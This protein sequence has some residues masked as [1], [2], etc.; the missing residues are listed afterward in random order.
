MPARPNLLLVMDDQHRPDWVGW[1]DVPVRTPNLDALRDRGVAFERAI[2]P[3]P[4]C[5]PAR[6]CIA[7]GLEYDR[8]YVRD[9]HEADYPLAAPTVYGH[10]RD[11]GGYHV[12]GAGKMDLQKYSQELGV[13]GKQFHREKGFSDL[14]NVE[15]NWSL[16][17]EAVDDPYKK[18]VHDNGYA[19][20]FDDYPAAVDE[21]DPVSLPQEAYQDDWIAAQGEALLRDAPTE[22]P[23]F[24]H[25]NFINP[26]RPWDVTEDMHDWY[27]DPPVDFPLPVDATDGEFDLDPETH[28]EIRRNYAAMIENV[29]RCFGRLLDVVEERGELDDTIVIFTSDHGEMLGDHGMWWKRSPYQPSAGV[30][31]VVAG[32]G[33]EERG[34]VDV[35]ATT[36]DLHATLR[37][38]AGIDTGAT[39]SRSMRPYLEGR[40]D[41]R[42]VVMSGVNYWRL[43]FDGRYKLIR[44]FDPSLSAEER[45]R[46]VDAWD[47]AA[48]ERSLREQDPLLFDLEQDPHEEDSLAAERDDVFDR[49]DASLDELR[50]R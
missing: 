46:D 33:V 44:G 6:A 12:L 36:L 27:R 32:P 4:V 42:D 50:M 30:P 25:V 41:P 14:V 21:T 17:S 47:E 11:D 13:D 43:A 2:T 39:D 40:G 48:L 38:Y 35:P 15:G 29:D 49:L 24:C 7:S 23:W 18:F 31:L 16:P 1:S 10:L 3:S 5:G 37:E 8:C 22:Q 20:V 45:L 9:H 28:Q 34:S 26:H 19:D